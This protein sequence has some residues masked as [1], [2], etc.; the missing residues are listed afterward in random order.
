MRAQYTEQLGW[1][2]DEGVDFVISETNDYL[3][4]ALIALEVA[5]ELGL[6]AMVTLA[7]DRPLTRRLAEGARATAEALSWDRELDRLDTS[8]R[9]VCGQS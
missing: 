1:A 9:E 4:E 8:Y 6:P 7:S 5:K 2:V 3:G